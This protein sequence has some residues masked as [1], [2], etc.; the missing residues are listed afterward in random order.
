MAV[1]ISERRLEPLER[2]RLT[3]FYEDG[4]KHMKGAMQMREIM[5][6]AQYFS[7]TPIKP[8][9]VMRELFQSAHGN[10]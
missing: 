7:D 3:A 4:E 2:H 1:A 9:Q 5:A 8:Y 10:R 6:I